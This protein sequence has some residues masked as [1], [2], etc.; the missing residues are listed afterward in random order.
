[1]AVCSGEHVV[2]GRSPVPSTSGTPA[3]PPT[4]CT[5]PIRRREVLK[6]GV[7]SLGGLSLPRL[8]EARASTHRDRRDTSAILL[9]LHGGA[10]QLETFDLKPDAPEGMRSVF[11]PISTNVAGIDI[12]EHFPNLARVADRFALVRSLN[13]EMAVHSDGQIEVMTG[14]TPARIDPTSNSKS[15]HPDV[16]HI[17]A[18]HRGRD[19]E[20]LPRYVAIPAPLYATPPNYVGLDCKAFS[21]SD[22]SLPGFAPLGLALDGAARGLDGRRALLTCLDERRR[23]ADRRADLA[24]MDQ[25]QELAI[26]LL[27][28]TAV[29]RAFD[30]EHEDP[31]LR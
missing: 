25:F 10:S 4:R 5:G 9:F 28:S 1:L 20:G 15:E 12:C 27:T 8:L 3:M 31:R 11:R 30:L 22:P 23:A 17:T 24:A 2:C 29:A 6:A 16:G 19:A 18:H 21:V 26:R 13:H 7:L 14:K